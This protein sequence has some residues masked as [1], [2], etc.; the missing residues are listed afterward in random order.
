MPIVKRKS[1]PPVQSIARKPGRPIY[2]IIKELDAQ[3]SDLAWEGRFEEADAAQAAADAY[4]ERYK[5]G[6]LHDPEF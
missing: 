6:E 3:A 4:R 1:L 5:N 2:E